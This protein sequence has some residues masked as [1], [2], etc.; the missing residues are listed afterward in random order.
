[1]TARASP[2]RRELAAVGTTALGNVSYSCDAAHGWELIA[3]GH[4][5]VCA[6]SVQTVTSKAGA[7]GKSQRSQVGFVEDNDGAHGGVTT[8]LADATQE[9]PG[10]PGDSDGAYLGWASP[11]GS[12]LIGSI[13][14]DGHLRFGSFRDGRFTQLPALPV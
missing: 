7:C 11:D 2:A 6:G 13:I 3:N 4:G 14:A 10:Q 12:T 5:V 9:C 1:M 8:S